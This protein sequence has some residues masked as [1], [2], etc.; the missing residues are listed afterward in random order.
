MTTCK[1]RV[2][3]TFHGKPVGS[4]ERP[5]RHSVR[6]TLTLPAPFTYRQAR[7]AAFKAVQEPEQALDSPAYVVLKHGHIINIAFN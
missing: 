6:R 2:T 5:S 7:E 4:Q 3:I 1:P